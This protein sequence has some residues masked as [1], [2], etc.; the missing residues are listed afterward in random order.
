[1]ISPLEFSI[2]M[3]GENLDKNFEVPSYLKK[4]KKILRT[5]SLEKKKKYTS[6]ASAYDQTGIYNHPAAIIASSVLHDQVK[7]AETDF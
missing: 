4:Q 3:A 7:C 5:Q 1:M 6:L 2:E